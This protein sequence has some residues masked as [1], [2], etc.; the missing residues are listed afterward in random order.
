MNVALRSD[1]LNIL[2]IC[3]GGAGLDLGLELAVQ[4][5]RTVCMV[6]REAFAVAQ[7][8]SAMEACLLASAPIWSDARTFNGRQWR[9]AVD[10]LIGGIPC[11]PHS[12]AGKRLAEEDERDLWSTARRIIVQ[13]GVCSSSLKTFE[14]CSHRA[15][16]SG[17]DET[18]TDW[19][20]RLRED[21]SRRQKSARLMRE[22]AS[23]SSQSQTETLAR[24]TPTANMV[25]GP[26]SNGR[27]GGDNL[28][29]AVQKF[30]PSAWPTPTA[31][32]WK[33]SGPTMERSDGKMRGDRLDYATEQVWSIDDQPST[34]TVNSKS[35][36]VWSTP[37]A[38][39]GEKGGPNQ[40]FGAGGVPLPAQASQWSTP[41]VADTTGGRM[42]RSGMRS[43]EPLLKGQAFALSDQWA[44]PR[45]NEVGQWQYANP[46]QTKKTLTL[47]GQAFSHPDPTI[48]Q[49]GETSSKERRS[50]NPLFVE[51][52]MGWPQ[53]WTLLAWTDFAC[54]AT[55]LSRW[56]QRMRSALS[57]LASPQEAPPAQLALFG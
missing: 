1:S 46:Q 14:E 9:G 26:G 56:N 23:S 7:L 49:V 52:L 42:A 34:S 6:E 10:G 20:L 53:G 48:L 21:C 36:D 5:A 30:H 35:S 47:T 22:S 50:L 55:E 54:S 32:D 17:S 27:D 41:S 45:S 8:V 57:Q 12:L 37:R 40:S 51:W 39:D 24:P 4:G 38:S 16:L 25:T 33:G 19:A 28:Q 29:T 44:T 13:S 3:T 31:N 11:Q 2:S 18:F 43:D 15:A